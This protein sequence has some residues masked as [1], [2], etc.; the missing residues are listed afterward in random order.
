MKS[1][2]ALLLIA[3]G[4]FVISATQP[5]AANSNLSLTESV[6]AGLMAAKPVKGNAVDRE[7]FNGKPILVVFFASW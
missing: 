4:A 1:I 3:V 6:K 5:A 2:R 7:M